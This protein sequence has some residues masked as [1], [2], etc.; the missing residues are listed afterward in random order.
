MFDIYFIQIT[1]ILFLE[2]TSLHKVLLVFILI[3][4]SVS[5]SLDVSFV[6]E[7]SEKDCIFSRLLTVFCLPIAPPGDGKI[8]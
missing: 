4:V 7:K 8:K 2:I 3:S 1:V 5:D 6:T